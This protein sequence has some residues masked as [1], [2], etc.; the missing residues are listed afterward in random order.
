MPG[1]HGVNH[2][3]E[4]RGRGEVIEVDHGVR[5]SSAGLFFASLERTTVAPVGNVDGVGF[6]VRRN[7]HVNVM[8]VTVLGEIRDVRVLGVV[9][10]VGAQDFYKPDTLH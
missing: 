3:G 8:R 2:L 6:A 10:D 7:R 5:Q 9:F 4:R 1:P